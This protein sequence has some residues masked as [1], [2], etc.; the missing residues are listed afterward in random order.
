VQEAL[1]RR[2][3]MMVTVQHRHRS[4]PGIRTITTSDEYCRQRRNTIYAPDPRFR[5]EPKFRL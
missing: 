4:A 3:R 5:T 2:E 1:A